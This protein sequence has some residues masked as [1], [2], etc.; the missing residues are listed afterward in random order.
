MA[1]EL[2]LLVEWSLPWR[3]FKTSLRPALSRSPDSLSGE[4]PT[5][6]FPLRGLLLCWLVEILLLTLA[7]ML[8]P[9]LTHLATPPPPPPKYEIV[10]YSGDTLPQAEDATG[11]RAGRSGE[12]GGEQAHNR[13]QT[14]RVARAQPV[15]EKV[16]DAP[17]IDLPTSSAAVA[18][19]LAFQA[20][21]GPAPLTAAA[22][23]RRAALPISPIA[24]APELNP[25]RVLNPPSLR[26]EVV[27]PPPAAL[28]H[29]LPSLQPPGNQAV[30]IVAPPVSAPTRISRETPRLTLPAA[31][32]V[33]PPPTVTREASRTGSGLGSTPLSTPIVPPPASLDQLQSERRA[34]GSPL[35]SDTVVPPAAQLDASA[36]PHA[37]GGALDR[38][39]V[40]GPPPSAAGAALDGGA[41]G[42]PKMNLAGS[43]EAG[44]PPRAP[45]SKPSGG[46]ASGV[47]VSTTPGSG[48]GVPTHSPGSI[49]MSPAGAE[50][51]GAGGSGGG[52]S[53]GRGEKT[54]S[55]LSGAGHGAAAAGE[56]RASDPAAR[57][58]ISRYPGAGG[59]GNGTSTKPAVPGVSVSGGNSVVTLPSFGTTSSPPASGG[60]SR[61]ADESRGPGIT[62]VGT[63]RSGGAFNFYGA[64]KGDRVY[65]I[66]I[67]TS[68]GPAVMQFAD[69]SSASHPY[70]E[71]L[72]APQ[73]LR[74]ALPGG[75]VLSRLVIACILDRNGS[76][77]NLQVLE[78]ASP[79]VT[80]KVMAALPGWKF[81]PAMHGD[82]PVEVTAIL[83]FAIDTR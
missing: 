8:P 27:P 58:G 74:A 49:A 2:K 66:Y 17:K 3:E 45:S 65:T 24:P 25:E 29:D 56:E 31:S 7:I 52:S 72:G 75:L 33:A 20:I 21:P 82:Q 23:D 79:E 34:A 42:R 57:N 5:G 80:R 47:V 41:S 46:S 69:P 59:S 78:S 6:L 61:E 83:G 81:S 28:E 39:Q 18:N 19:L 9:R 40:V 44:A 4:V 30:Q 38:S 43:V 64:L 71:D 73:P 76:L 68:A 22:S 13:Q 37:R 55:G 26:A 51:P 15:R 16:V 70:A 63:S 1:D 77:R 14:I 60:R 62:V 48:V 54:G 12:G 67:E 11:A 36:L 50:K 35:A 10:Y 32:V 53:L